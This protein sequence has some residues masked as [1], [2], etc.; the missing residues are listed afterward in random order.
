MNLSL[1]AEIAQREQVERELVRVRNL[2]SLGILAGGIAHDFNNLLTIVQGN[3]QMAKMELTPGSDILANLEDSSMACQR[4]SLLSSQLL[5][6]AKGGAP[7]RRVVSMAKL[8]SDA[9]Q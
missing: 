3:I 6:F 7:M 9:V 1:R 2:E 8:V 4:A 5:T